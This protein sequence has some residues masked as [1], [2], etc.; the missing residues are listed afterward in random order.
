MKNRVIFASTL[1]ILSI[2]ITGC[3]DRKEIEDLGLVA[4][5]AIDNSGNAA[6][7][8]ERSE[9]NDF[10]AIT[11]QFLVA[12]ALGGGEK[13]TS[14]QKKPYVNATLSGSSVFQILNDFYSMSSREP[15]YEHMKV[16][17]ISGEAARSF[18]LYL[19]LNSL[20]RHPEVPRNTNV[21]ISEGKA[22]SMLEIDPKLEDVPAFKLNMLARDV[23]R[24]TKKLP[25][26]TLGDMSAKMAAGVSF[27]IQRV[28]IRDDAIQLAGAAIIRGREFKLAGW[29]DESETDGLC[30][31]MGEVGGGSVETE[32]E[33]T[34]Q[35]I[36]CRIERGKSKITPKM[37]EGSIAF[38]VEI[39][40]EASIAEDWIINADAL[41]QEFI[42]RVEKAVEKE[43]KSKVLK[44]LHKLQKEYKTDV[45]G[46]GKQVGIK[47][48]GLWSKIKDG[49]D[50]QFSDV[51]V[52]VN[53]D[54]SVRSYGR[55]SSKK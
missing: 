20:L 53:V 55:Q 45:A 22:A 10:I 6:N 27:A 4:G 36:T 2:A 12:K 34:G 13:S 3:W 21:V 37:Q 44:T 42:D 23:K 32:D 50:E 8:E 43:V 1:L 39:E 49:W 26:L 24:T 16:I 25:V 5:M 31:L 9:N 18:N 52:D 19:L 29:L 47:Y 30:W 41:K 51:A 38:K 28:V 54:V 33:K 17:I 35:T 15:N 40:S 14:S 7:T 48:P 46:F 11:N